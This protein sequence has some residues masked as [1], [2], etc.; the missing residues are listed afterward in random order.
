[1]FGV[2]YKNIILRHTKYGY[3]LNNL[4]DREFRKIINNLRIENLSLIRHKV[5]T[6]KNKKH[7]THSKIF[8]SKRIINSYTNNDGT[9]REARLVKSRTRHYDNLIF[10]ESLISREESRRL[11]LGGLHKR[12]D[13]FIED[14]AHVYTKSTIKELYLNMESG[15]KFYHFTDNQFGEVE[16]G[17]FKYEVKLDFIDPTIKYVENLMKEAKLGMESIEG[18]LDRV[19]IVDNYDY[20]LE[21]IRDDF[22]TE[23]LVLYDNVDEAPWIKVVKNYVRY[24]NFFYDLTETE[25]EFLLS[26]SFSKVHPK[27]ATLGSIKSFISEYRKILKNLYTHF[28]ISTETVT[29][30]RSSNNKS[31]LKKEPLSNLVS[32]SKIFKEIVDTKNYKIFYNFF[33]E[34][35]QSDISIYSRNDLSPRIADERSQYVL[36]GSE[37]IISPASVQSHRKIIDI[38]S[39][40]LATTNPNDIF[41][42]EY[43]RSVN[44]MFGNVEQKIENLTVSV[45]PPQSYETVHVEQDLPLIESTKILGDDTKFNQYRDDNDLCQGYTVNLIETSGFTF[46][47]AESMSLEPVFENMTNVDPVSPQMEADIITLIGIKKT[48]IIPMIKH[49]NIQ[50]I[51]IL[52]GFEET[53]DGH[54]MTSIPIWRDMTNQDLAESNLSFFCRIVPLW[55][56]WTDLLSANEAF[57]KTDL[58]IKV[59]KYFFISDFFG[60]LNT[61]PGLTPSSLDQYGISVANSLE[62][63]IDLSTSNIVRQNIKVDAEKQPMIGAQPPE[64]QVP[65]RESINV[66]GQLGG[67][68]GETTGG[69]AGFTG[70]DTNNTG[71]VTPSANTSGG[72]SGASSAS[73][74]TSGGGSASSGGGS[75]SSGGGSMS[76]GGGY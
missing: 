10:P 7:L 30:S 55:D 62:Y 23:E 21:S 60:G 25:T 11:Q 44:E 26:T 67:V 47:L 75:M 71:E 70:S 58:P 42:E 53:S 43:I 17:Q 68:G 18:Y 66:V 50:K 12:Q 65:F 56:G 14:L 48:A 19:L 1:M 8:E 39:Y 74:G 54:K 76:S 59:D 35:E 49:M 20:H 3:N 31:R 41:T 57:K 61:P 45:E 37:V 5:R 6:Y 27:V 40:N 46:D 34:S 13:I 2:N 36:S 69:V 52:A 38:F 24:L 72:T 15:M 4:E 33:S 51:Q 22:Y 63:N 16:K 9:F 32:V 73:G 64:I 29:K 28:D